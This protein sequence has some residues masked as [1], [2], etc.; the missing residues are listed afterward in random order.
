VLGPFLLRP[1]SAHREGS[2]MDPKRARKPKVTM[3]VEGMITKRVVV[4]ES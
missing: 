3:G 1:A 4:P 2:A